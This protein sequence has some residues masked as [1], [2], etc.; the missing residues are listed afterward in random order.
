MKRVINR[1]TWT[2]RRG[3]LQRPLSLAVA[4]DLHNAP[5]EEL[6]PAM[7]GVDAILVVGDLI[8]RHYHGDQTQARA[9]LA[10]APEIAP[11]YHSLG[12]HEQR[13]K[14]AEEW[15][16]VLAESR[17][18]V[19]DDEAVLLRED[20]VLGGLTSQK[21]S[22]R[23]DSR[24]VAALAEREAFRLLMCHHPEDYFPWVA[25]RGIDLT[26]AG[27]AHGGQVRIFGQGLYAPGQGLFPRL[28]S[29][30]YD[31]DRLLVSRGLSNHALVP[32]FNNPCEL[33]LLTLLPRAK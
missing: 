23:R 10:R 24:V 16:A 11:V 5:F 28:T 18:T 22:S 26:L 14:H 31:E 9:F 7:A 17:V 13:M 15:R 27:H 33:I 21:K 30:F 2:D 32:R 19:L 3:A 12:N 4:A 29:G 8:N 25:G 20:V 6:L 1:L